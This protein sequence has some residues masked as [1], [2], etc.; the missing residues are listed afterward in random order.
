MIADVR[1]PPR[2]EP[3][4][5]VHHEQ[6]RVRSGSFQVKLGVSCWACS[7]SSAPRSSAGTDWRANCLIFAAGVGVLGAG[8]Q[9]GWLRSKPWSA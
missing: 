6:T 4:G 2:A 7:C 5:A 1:H 3:I 9:P 8:L